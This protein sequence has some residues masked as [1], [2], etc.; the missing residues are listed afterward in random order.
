MHARKAKLQLGSRDLWLLLLSFC[1]W[2]LKLYIN[3]VESVRNNDIVYVTKWQDFGNN[4][5]QA[6]ITLKR[7][8]ICECIYIWA[9]FRDRGVWFMLD[10]A[11]DITERIIKTFEKI[12]P[13][14]SPI[15]NYI[16]LL[17]FTNVNLGTDHNI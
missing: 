15:W 4:F 14:Q 10:G 2:S 12:C 13:W 3:F 1:L 17:T 11:G 9:S 8:L 6:L 16:L 7:M 5:C